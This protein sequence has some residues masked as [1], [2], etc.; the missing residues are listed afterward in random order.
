MRSATLGPFTTDRLILRRWRE[1][2]KEP[3]AALNADPRTMEFFP[4]TLDRAESDRVADRIE[5]RFEE[6]GFGLWALEE[7]SSGR[8]IGFAGLSMPVFE[9]H[10]TPCVEIGWRLCVGAWG[11][12][13]ASEAARYAL[14]FGYLE[15]G[16]NEIVSMTVAGNVRSRRVM[17]RLGMSHDPKED[18]DHPGIAG[19]SQLRQHV[20]YRLSVEKWRV[21][22]HHFKKGAA[23]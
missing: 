14:Q 9:A 20:L 13:Y 12:G 19:H 2:D 17:E 21:R 18:F 7:R 5:M 10:F 22:E 16:L 11:K 3:F 23:A 8:F 4:K 1:T 15:R 6:R